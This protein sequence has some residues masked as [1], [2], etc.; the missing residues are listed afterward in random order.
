M[1]T[2]TV[3]HIV[4]RAGELGGINFPVDPHMLRHAKGYQLAARGE[5]TGVLE[6]QKH[7]AHRAVH[8]ADPRRFTGFGRD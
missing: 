8:Q 6:V 3:H 2:R 1:T 7:T 5:D 4:A